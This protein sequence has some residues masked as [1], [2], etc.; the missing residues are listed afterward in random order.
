MGKKTLR[1]WRTIR[2]KFV[3]AR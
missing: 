1:S 3:E 2:S